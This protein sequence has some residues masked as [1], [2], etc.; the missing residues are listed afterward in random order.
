MHQLNNDEEQSAIDIALYDRHAPKIFLYIYQQL[1]HQQDTE[2]V[3]LEVFA[4]ALESERFASLSDGEQLAWLRR[5]ARNK[6]VD[7][8]RHSSLLQMAPLEELADVED[9]DLTPEQCVI[10]KEQYAQLHRSVQYLS[11][12]QQEILLLRYGHGLRLVEIAGLLQKPEGTVRKFLSRTLRR[13][14]ACYEQE[15]REKR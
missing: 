3:L 7:R 11:T 5:V 10:R 1:G 13:L 2:D 12:E 4:A 9:E 15:C 8:Y 14:R 6:V